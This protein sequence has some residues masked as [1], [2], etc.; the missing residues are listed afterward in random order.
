MLSCMRPVFEPR[1]SCTGLSEKYRCFFPFNVITLTLPLPISHL[2]ENYLP[3]PNSYLCEIHICT[4]IN[5]NG[6]ILL[7]AWLKIAN[8][9]GQW[10]GRN[11]LLHFYLCDVRMRI[12]LTCIVPWGYLRGFSLKQ[13]SASGGSFFRGKS[14]KEELMASPSY[15]DDYW[16]K[17]YIFYFTK[18][19]Y[20]FLIV[21]CIEISFQWL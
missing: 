18:N 11:V 9:N 15:G 20:M 14:V 17:I 16:G 1:W 10:H 21:L 12:T 19:I 4:C 2:C 3:L 6:D 5:C 8:K 7:D 13:K